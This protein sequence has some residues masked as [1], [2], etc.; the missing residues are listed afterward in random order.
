MKKPIIKCCAIL[1]IITLTLTAAPVSGFVG[2]G[3]ELLPIASAA[4]SG[5]YTYRVLS[6][7]TAEIT[8]YI[9]AGGDV[10]IPDTIDGYTV[11]SI[12]YSAFY[13]CSV[14]TTVAIGDSVTTIGDHAFDSCNA[15]T[16]VDIPDSVTT[17]GDYAF[18]DCDALTA[19]TVAAEN[20]SYSSDAYGVLY[21]KDK[22]TL[23]QYPIGNP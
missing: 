5:D 19:I 7:G 18:S 20:P 2:L 1:L 16:T 6:G 14:L 11:T 17:I 9:G 22:T 8:R 21:N 15:L 4:T 12:G 23:I 13:E 10:V 3:E